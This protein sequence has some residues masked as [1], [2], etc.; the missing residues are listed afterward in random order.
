[1]QT[2]FEFDVTFIALSTETII[3]S[4]ERTEP[5]VLIVPEVLPRTELRTV[6]VP[7]A[8]LISLS[9]PAALLPQMTEFAITR[10]PIGLYMP[11][12]ASFAEL[13]L[14]VQFMTIGLLV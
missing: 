8:T 4:A 3:G 2:S 1:M 10:L 13:S 7:L 14:N 6:V 9:A 11:P 5:S 12:P